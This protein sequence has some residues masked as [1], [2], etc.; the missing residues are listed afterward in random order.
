MRYGLQV[1]SYCTRAIAFAHR[2]AAFLVPYTWGFPYWHQYRIENGS[3][4]TDGETVLYYPCQFRAVF[5]D[6]KPE[7]EEVGPPPP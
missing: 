3:Y 1:I 5:K 7:W 6:G 4:W 2:E